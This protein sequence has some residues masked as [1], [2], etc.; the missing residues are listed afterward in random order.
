MASGKQEQRPGRGGL[1]PALKPLLLR[2]SEREGGVQEQLRESQVSTGSQRCCCCRDRV[3]FGT[4]PIL[5][6]PTSME[7]NEGTNNPCVT[8]GR[9]QKAIGAALSL[10][11][12]LTHTRYLNLE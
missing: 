8:W 10:S 2:E 5:E 6:S 3:M 11:L 9:I 4:W 12:S 1:H 7:G